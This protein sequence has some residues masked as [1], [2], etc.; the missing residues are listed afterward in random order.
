MK[1]I[2]LGAIQISSYTNKSRLFSDWRYEEYDEYKKQITKYDPKEEILPKNTIFTLKIDYPLTIPFKKKF[3]TSTNLITRRQIIN[4]IVKCYKQVYKEENSSS[5]RKESFIP[6][7]FNRMPSEGKY[8][9][10]GHV[11]EDLVLVDMFINKNKIISLG[12]DS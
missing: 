12:V 4:F 5:S 2:Q 1:M 7:M 10:W 8:G 6:G 11:L 3:N 9:I